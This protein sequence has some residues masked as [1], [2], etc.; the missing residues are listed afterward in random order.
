[1]KVIKK[2]MIFALITLLYLVS[3]LILYINDFPKNILYLY[4]SLMF[5]ILIY[6][7]TKLGK[8]VELEIQRE[9]SKIK[10]W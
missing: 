10:F 7:M 6:F 2:Y 3:I 9:G 8:L 1:M 5:P 4:I